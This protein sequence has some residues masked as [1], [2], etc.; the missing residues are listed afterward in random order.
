M[1]SCERASHS[2]AVRYGLDTA[3]ASGARYYDAASRGRQ[4][5]DLSVPGHNVAMIVERTY[6]G[7]EKRA[8][9]QS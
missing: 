8:L 1:P 6:W 7:G 5:D 4:E 9:S 3:H 2:L